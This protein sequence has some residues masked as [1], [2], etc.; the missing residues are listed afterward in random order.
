MLLHIVCNE[1]V[2]FE[3]VY[4]YYISVIQYN[5]YCKILSILSNLNGINILTCIHFVSVL[6]EI[7]M[8][9]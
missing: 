5:I 4:D 8:A 3:F 7:L 6:I 9:K 2:Y 1:I